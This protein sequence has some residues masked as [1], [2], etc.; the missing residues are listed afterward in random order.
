MELA[1]QGELTRRFFAKGAE[2]FLSNRHGA[3]ANAAV[4]YAL[5]GA[6]TAVGTA[7]TVDALYDA[8]NPRVETATVVKDVTP[9]VMQKFQVQDAE[10]LAAELVQAAERGLDQS[11]AADAEARGESLA[12][13]QED[14]VVEPG[15]S[16][17]HSLPDVSPEIFG[18]GRYDVPQEIRDA[19]YDAAIEADI[20]P[21]LL[22]AFA[23]KESSFRSAIKARQ[24]DAKGLFQFTENTWFRVLK[25]FGAD[26]GYVKEAN[27][28]I[29][30]QKGGFGAADWDTRNRLLEL[31][32]DPVANSRFAAALLVDNKRRV[33]NRLGREL[34]TTEM[35]ITH[36]LGTRNALAFLSRVDR[37]PEAVPYQSKNFAGPAVRNAPFFFEG[38]T[39]NGR[40]LTYR[41]SFRTIEADMQPRVDYFSIMAAKELHDREEFLVSSVGGEEIHSRFEMVR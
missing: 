38:G 14:A 8:V 31:R 20:H 26:L 9:D 28:V 30:N 13:G 15:A 25:A 7:V 10:R 39:P 12:M 17:L 19:I 2:I 27:D 21:G 22:M 5:V 34:D 32:S 11:E 37:K 4:A 24:S 33:E 41:E 35:Y 40:P 29:V 1:K 23:S 18:L 3:T 16:G 6:F 36:L